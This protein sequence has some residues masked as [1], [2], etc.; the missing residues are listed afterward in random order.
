MA[1]IDHARRNLERA[2]L[3]QIKAV[4]TAP[5]ASGRA[6]DKWSYVA[7]LSATR[8][9]WN[10]AL[11]RGVRAKTIPEDQGGRLRTLGAM[12]P[13][14]PGRSPAS[15]P[16]ELASQFDPISPDVLSALGA[17]I[18]EQ[19]RIAVDAA[20]ASVEALVAAAGKALVPKPATPT[21]ASVSPALQL[22]AS[23]FVQQHPGARIFRRETITPAERIPTPPPAAGSAAKPATAAARATAG[24]TTESEVVMVRP[25]PPA[26]EPGPQPQL[27]HLPL[28]ALISLVG[29]DSA[30]AAGV[31]PALALAQQFGIAAEK[32][33][34]ANFTQALS[35]TF[36]GTRDVLYSFGKRMEVEPVGLLHLERVGFT[37]AGIERG[38]LVYSV[39]LSPGE[40]VNIAHKEWSTQSEEFQTIVTDFIEQYSEQGVAE[41]SELTQS[42]TSQATHSTG[43]SL[44]V[45]ASG[46]YGPVSISTSTNFN[47]A[48]SAT[49]S[50][51]AARHESSELTRKASSRAKKEHKSSFKVASASGTSDQSV[52]QI[53]NP[54][55]DKA[56]RVDYYQLIR[57]W[58]VDLFRYGVRLTYD[59]A[60]PEPGSEI[61]ARIVQIEALSAAL[62]QGFNTK[63]STASW[64]RFDT[65]V[66]DIGRSTY[67]ALAGRY[68]A[69]VSE[70]P[71]D[72]IKIYRSFNHKWATEAEV[73][74]REWNSYAIEVPEGYEVTGQWHK[75]THWQWDEDHSYFGAYNSFERWLGSTKTVS[76]TVETQY[77]ISYDIEM[78]VTFSLTHE[79]YHAWQMKVWGQLYDAAKS[80]YELNRA[81]LRDQ[82]AALQD[83][84]G[85]QDAL[86]L[87]QIEREEVMKN[88][89]RWLFG[90][91]FTFVPPGV[92]ADLY[93]EDESVKSQVWS[94]VLAQGEV[95]KFLHHAIEWENML[96]ILYPY[97]W[98]DTTH[99]E[100]KKYLDHPDFIHR[101]FLRAGSARVVL[102]IRP[103]YETDFVS[104]LE[105][106]TFDPLP[107]THPYMTVAEEM[108]AYAQ[109]NY[110]GVR[111]ANP[112]E[113]ARPLLSP[114]QSRAWHAMQEIIDLLRK[115]RRANG[116]YPTTEQGLAALA[117]L[118][119]VPP[120]D[121]WGKPY[122][123]EAPGPV[124]DF[125]LWS[126]GADGRPGGTDENADINSWAKSSLI[127]RWYEYTPTSALDIAFNETMPS[128]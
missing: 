62:R 123:Y 59:L 12:L 66:S 51:Q 14:A 11:E 126:E 96:Y 32:L 24:E 22:D 67:A 93:N 41:K 80:G 128:A 23:A 13:E 60:I 46:G 17:E 36:H 50:E 55:A 15:L 3:T 30:E 35:S 86:S 88:V 5:R 18:A 61:L 81:T 73:E 108:Q 63:D 71:V 110:P 102:T 107:G 84:L 29:E 83:Q 47:M 49:Q 1:V 111:S 43:F 75:S 40:H 98:S 38:E 101:A 20:R 85:A 87:R 92:P 4:K 94:R 2:T 124:A 77:Q 37:P 91:S 118:G 106:G 103:G 25:A 109:T 53:T 52:R 6:W 115:Y 31:K 65:R 121:P 21:V 9:E 56:T 34:T 113:E 89:L 64:A 78:T 19:R 119:T 105:T 127:G 28:S 54:F 122:H 74:H 26:A 27:S 68:G 8:A 10:G 114:R 125:Q 90:P 16:L 45:T 79:A 42:T 7:A 95:I 116:A 100:F 82:L 58:Q 44:G 69:V 48:S 57:R 33:G 97:F 76:L 104:F 99:W 117:G 39:P 72:T 120:T 70:P 112:D